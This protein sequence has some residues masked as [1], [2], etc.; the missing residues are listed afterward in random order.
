[1]A[2]KQIKRFLIGLFLVI[3]LF[4]LA[5]AE[6]ADA[7]PQYPGLCETGHADLYTAAIIIR[8]FGVENAMKALRIA[9]CESWFNPYAHNPQQMP[10]VCFNSN[11]ERGNGSAKRQVWIAAL[12]LDITDIQTLEPPLIWLSRKKEEVGTI[13]SVNNSFSS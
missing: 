6:D 3:W 8:E 1:M 12:T 2:F 11:Q 5:L 4:V 9:S 10:Q 7:T 13:G